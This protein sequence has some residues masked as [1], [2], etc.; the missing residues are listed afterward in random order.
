MKHIYLLLTLALFSNTLIAQDK[1]IGTWQ[2][3]LNVGQELD[4]AFNISNSDKGLKATLDVPAQGAR[5]ISCSGVTTKEDSVVINIALINGKFEG[6][7]TDAKTINGKWSQGIMNAPLELTRSEGKIELK[8]P[9]TPKPPYS[10]NSEDVIY[11]NKDKSIQFGATITSPNDN[12]KHPALVLIT[13]SGAQNRNEEAFGHQP[14]AVIADHLTKNGY[15]V[16][17]VDD[18]GVGETTGDANN[19]TSADYAKDVFAGI[20]FLKTRKEVDK[21]KIGLLGHSEGG[22]IAPMVATQSK[23]IDFIVLLAG[24]GT[25]LTQGMTEQN[26]AV[27]TASGMSVQLAT[28]YGKLYYDI[29]NI[30]ATAKTKEQATHEVHTTI[31]KWRADTDSTAVL[32]T[33]GIY[34]I[35]SQ[36]KFANAFLKLYDSEW[37]R[38]FISYDPEL[39]LSKLDCKVL[40]L[41]GEKDIQV[42]PKSNLAGITAALKRSDSKVY[43]VKE[44]KGVNHLFQ[45]CTTCNAGEY[46]QLEQ[47][48]KPEVLDIITQW[49]DEHVK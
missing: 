39:V 15:V 13:G 11:H 25:K 37:F 35:N 44:I 4:V 14:F 5:D 6:M 47:T 9:Q 34:D 36:N 38:F 18:R 8:R 7:M 46:G 41:N 1:F 45:E 40:A 21:S 19:A 30:L 10:Y 22:M 32:N 49:L 2:G 31:D 28:T 42:L 16:L 29:V 43:D 27:L 26:I 24:P 48:I 20:E 33:T 23:D 12:D 17:R 3:T